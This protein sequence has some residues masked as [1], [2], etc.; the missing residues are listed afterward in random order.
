[1]GSTK[2]AV[3]SVAA[4]EAALRPSEEPDTAGIDQSEGMEERQKWPRPVVECRASHMHDAFGTAYFTKLGLFS[5][6]QQFH[7]FQNAT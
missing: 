4:V 6:Q 3:H 2:T 7:R 1:M 5:L